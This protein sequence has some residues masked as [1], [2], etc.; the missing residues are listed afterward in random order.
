LLPRQ[1]SAV[2]PDEST[3][4][5]LVAV[6]AAESKKAS[7]IKVL[8]LRDVT[9]FANYFVICTGTNPR[10]LRAIAEEIILTMKH[11]G[12]P[13]NSAEGLDSADWVLVDCGDLLVHV[14]SEKAREFYD[15]ERLWRHAKKVDL[16]AWTAAE[17]DA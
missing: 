8:D 3:P 10:Q 17:P 15:L 4:N 12:E 14:F 2:R 13:A 11:H 5:W 9:T 7:D 16:S 6:R 1:K